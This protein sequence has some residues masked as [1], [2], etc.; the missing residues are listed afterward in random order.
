MSGSKKKVK[1]TK[2]VALSEVKD[3]LSK[4]LRM[5]ERGGL[6]NFGPVALIVRE[7]ATPELVPAGEPG[8]VA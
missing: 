4:Y 3:D 2:E 8:C 6:S 7:Q 1:R 5:A